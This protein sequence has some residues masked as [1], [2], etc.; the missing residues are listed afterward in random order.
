VSDYVNIATTVGLGVAGL[1]F[2]QSLRRKT[3]AEI[4]A[5]VAERR[6]EA[7]S[8]LWEATLV[9]APSGRDALSANERRALHEEF[10]T[11]YFTG[12]HG[13]VL[14]EDTRNI[15]LTAKNNLT[16]DLEALQPES[17]RARLKAAP[18]SSRDALRGAASVRQLSLLRTSMR[19]DLLVYTGPWG[20]R[21]GTEDRHFL[22]ACGVRRWRRPWRP[23]LR[24]TAPV[25]PREEPRA[26]DATAGTQTVDG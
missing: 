19:A 6:L 2:G 9:A 7:Y 16:C 8:A 5:H 13:M 24:N 11:W 21:L 25:G 20:Q 26:V 23:S 1:Y 15:Y 4:E 14:S 22:A 17:L 10:T 3:R 12:G 18:G